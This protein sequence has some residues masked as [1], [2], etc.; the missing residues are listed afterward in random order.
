[1]TI[2]MLIADDHALMRGLLRALLESHAGWEVCGE[3]ENGYAAVLKSAELK[4]DL[5]ILDLAMPVMDG[6]HAAREISTASPTLPIII[7]TQ[8]NSSEIESE[9]KKFGVRQVIE[10]ADD[11][12]KLL[13]AVEE[14]L[15]EKTTA[16]PSETRLAAEINAS[17]VDVT[18]SAAQLGN[19]DSTEPG[20]PGEDP[21]P[22]VE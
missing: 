15:R 8:H 17:I 6:L 9:A 19:A 13:A 1:M 20:I 12:A 21:T 10:K 2:R 18:P 4:P 5:V 22:K 3:A 7:H 16:A 14:L 11:G